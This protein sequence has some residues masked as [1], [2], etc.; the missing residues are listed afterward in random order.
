MCASHVLTFAALGLLAVGESTRAQTNV[1]IGDYRFGMTPT[2]VVEVT[3]CSPYRPVP[4]TR[5][6]ECP[7]FTVGNR[8]MNISF[9]F[10]AKGL[11]RIQLWFHE[12]GS[13][14]GA[15]VATD[16]ML[17]FLGKRGPTHSD[18][19]KGVPAL[20]SDAIF[21]DLNRRYTSGKGAR[22]QVLLPETSKPPHVYGSVTRLDSGYFVFVYFSASAGVAK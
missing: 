5:G 6:L 11:N 9:V 16:A 4:S 8:R 20:S 22:V 12:G 18:E 19:L 1:G 7:N 13:E 2:Q 3:S 21:Q 15:R 17:A 14:A 10:G